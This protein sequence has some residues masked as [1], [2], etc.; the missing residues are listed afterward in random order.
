MTVKSED[1]LSYNLA[2]AACLL[3]GLYVLLALITS[4][5]LQWF[6]GDQLSQSLLDQFSVCF[7]FTTS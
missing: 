7:Q 5:F 6:L 3:H 1:L 2:H 4:F